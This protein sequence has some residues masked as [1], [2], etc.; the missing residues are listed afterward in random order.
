[1]SEFIIR[2]Q[3]SCHPQDNES[4]YPGSLDEA[5]EDLDQRLSIIF[6]Q[7]FSIPI[8][9]EHI[10][11]NYDNREDEDPQWISPYPCW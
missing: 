2:I 5:E 3:A 9:I 7:I 1:M 10:E 6:D 11:I 4:I 8:T